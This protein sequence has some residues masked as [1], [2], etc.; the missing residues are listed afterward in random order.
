V[1]AVYGAQT[2]LRRDAQR[3]RAAIVRAA[4][5]VLN[6]RESG[7]QMP[8]IARRAGVAQATLYRH[9]PDRK[10]LTVAV[11]GH[12]LQELEASC[13]RA[14]GRPEMFRPLLRGAL[15]TQ[16]VLLPLVVLGLRLEPG[17]RRRCE[18]RVVK[19]FT[20][21]LRCAQDHGLVRRDLAP[22]DLM[23]LF[24]MV[25]GA[26]ETTPDL[27]AGRVA[28]ERSIELVLDGLFPT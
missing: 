22:G 10:L 25:R 24:A 6:S 9:F 23:V 15:H 5:A 2:S 16:I 1:T 13:A 7:A 3:N 17:A 19:A 12:H 21:P 20:P 18:Q 26:A 4:S 14:A 28:A 11:I 27:V 8:A